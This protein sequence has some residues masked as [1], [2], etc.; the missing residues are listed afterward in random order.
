VVTDTRH[1]LHTA[2]PVALEVALDGEGRGCEQLARPVAVALR[3][4]AVEHDV[5]AVVDRGAQAA[6]AGGA[7]MTTSR[8]AK[9]AASVL[10]AAIRPSSFTA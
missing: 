10:R 2:G 1:D 6:C 5:G 3:S 8:A 4:D 7:T 9:V